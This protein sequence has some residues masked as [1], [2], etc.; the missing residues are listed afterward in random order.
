M[1]WSAVVNG[2]TRRVEE[3]L[4]RGR[5]VDAFAHSVD[6]RTHNGLPP[7][8]HAAGYF[9]QP[10]IVKL[11]C[12]YGA[13]VNRACSHVDGPSTALHQAAF[14]G[15]AKSCQILLGFGADDATRTRQFGLYGDC[16]APLELAR[17]VMNVMD[18]GYKW[19]ETVHVLSNAHMFYRP[20]GLIPGSA[21][22]EGAAARQPETRLFP[23]MR[24][25]VVNG[26]VEGFKFESIALAEGADTEARELPDA[27]RYGMPAMAHLLMGVPPTPP[28]PPAPPP[29][30]TPRAHAN[31]RR[32][33]PE[34][35]AALAAS[36]ASAR[37]EEEL[38]AAIAASLAEGRPSTPEKATA[39]AMAA[40]PRTQQAHPRH[41][42][43]V[44]PSP[45]ATTLAASASA[46]PSAATPSPA[47][48]L[49]TRQLGDQILYHATNDAA[50]KS[51]RDTKTF[52]PSRADPSTGYRP[53]FGEMVRA[54]ST[55]L[56]FHS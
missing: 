4:K 31:E 45:L 26:E 35:V 6:Q 46:T 40:S 1:D 15:D 48:S 50:S 53:M 25:Q 38:R 37:E 39:T 54:D 43:R 13:D 10:E 42:A 17:N 18:D 2:D 32:D 14:H 36:R 30:R 19:R 51:I 34:L 21:S 5:D 33:D 24:V 11:L 12:E 7:L 27:S 16:R 41:N 20:P 44:P 49:E 23:G 56:P 47:G 8:H 3:D 22:P 29:A 9:S 28:P 52:L 55:R